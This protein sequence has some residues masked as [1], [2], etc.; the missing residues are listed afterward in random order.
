MNCINSIGRTCWIK[1]ACTPG[2]QRRNYGLIRAKKCY[3]ENLHIYFPIAIA[4]KSDFISRSISLNGGLPNRRA[5]VLGYINKSSRLDDRSREGM[6]NSF[7]F[8]RYDS[9]ICRLM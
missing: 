6:S 5:D 1:P 2:K 9:L 7:L 4:V 8:K 3:Q